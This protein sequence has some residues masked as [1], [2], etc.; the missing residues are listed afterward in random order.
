MIAKVS[1]YYAAIYLKSTY[2]ILAYRAQGTPTILE[3][4]NSITSPYYIVVE[5]II[6]YLLICF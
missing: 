3:Y 6:S 4:Y 2:V 1:C 5:V